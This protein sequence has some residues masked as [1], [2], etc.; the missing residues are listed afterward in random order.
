[1]IVNKIDN[2]KAVNTAKS[3]LVPITVLKTSP[4]VFKAT[5]EITTDKTLVPNDPAYC[6]IMLK[7]EF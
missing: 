2:D 3:I 1:M 5:A 7:S 4:L 6:C